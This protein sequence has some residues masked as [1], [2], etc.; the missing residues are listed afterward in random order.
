MKH[1]VKYLLLALLF[2]GCASSNDNVEQLIEKEAGNC[3][4]ADCT[5]NIADITSFKWD[6]M[7]AFNYSQPR[8]VIEKAIG[9]PYPDY[10]EGTRPLIFLYKNKIVHAENNPGVFAKTSKGQVIYSYELGLQ[11]KAYKPEQAVFKVKIGK[12]GGQT[13]YSLQR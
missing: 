7:Y 5:L 9:L 2:A 11:Y 3:K 13:F 10:Q 4:A 1:A 12:N 6:V 8:L